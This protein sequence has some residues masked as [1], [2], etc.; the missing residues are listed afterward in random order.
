MNKLVSNADNQEKRVR[1]P[2]PIIPGGKDMLQNLFTVVYCY[3][4]RRGGGGRVCEYCLCEVG[5]RE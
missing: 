4:K 1:F 3:L 2:C 5:G